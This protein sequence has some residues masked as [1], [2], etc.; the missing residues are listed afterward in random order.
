MRRNE[1]DVPHFSIS[2]SA[3]GVGRQSLLDGRTNPESS[4][5]FKALAVTLTA[6]GVEPQSA[7]VCVVASGI[8]RPSVCST[9]PC[10]KL[11]SSVCSFEYHV[12]NDI[13]VALLFVAL[14]KQTRYPISL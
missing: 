3:K 10:S 7:P 13:L 5:R 2:N 11:G 6:K 14:T 9:G 1:G 8:R 12:M 4:L